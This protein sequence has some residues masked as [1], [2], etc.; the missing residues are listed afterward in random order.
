MRVNWRVAVAVGETNDVA[1]TEEGTKVEVAVLRMEIDTVWLVSVRGNEDET[2]LALAL[3]SV[4][5]ED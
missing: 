5:G 3:V 2:R 1:L 4:T